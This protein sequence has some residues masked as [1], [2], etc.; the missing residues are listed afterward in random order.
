MLSSLQE[1]GEARTS[2]PRT[3]PRGEERE[4]EKRG[5]FL[6]SFSPKREKDSLQRRFPPLPDE[7]NGGLSEGKKEA[8]PFPFIGGA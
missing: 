3:I 1:G 8:Q 4:G 5:G 7:G 2:I 6:L